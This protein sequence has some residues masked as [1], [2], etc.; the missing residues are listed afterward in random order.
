[1]EYSVY[2]DQC[3]YF[4][5]GFFNFNF[6]FHWLY[7]STQHWSVRVDILSSHLQ[8][9]PY[10]DTCSWHCFSQLLFSSWGSFPVFIFARV[11]CFV[12]FCF[13][14]AFRCVHFP[15]CCIYCHKIINDTASPNNILISVESVVMQPFHS[16][17]LS[18]V[19]TWGIWKFPG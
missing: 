12:L 15:C 9:S 8:R 3:N 4:Y 14:M 2:K 13:G 7:V 6:L 11:F 1:M 5:W 17:C 19:L 18:F 10:H 16:C